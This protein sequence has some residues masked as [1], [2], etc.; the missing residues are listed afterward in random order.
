MIQCLMPACVVHA[1]CMRLQY[2]LHYSLPPTGAACC[3]E[4]AIIKILAA[5]ERQKQLW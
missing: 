1:W 2:N 5:L 3:A 4:A